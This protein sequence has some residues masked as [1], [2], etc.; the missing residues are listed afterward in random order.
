MDAAGVVTTPFTHHRRLSLRKG[1]DSMTTRT[2]NRLARLLHTA[3][4][5]TTRAL[6]LAVPC[7]LW[8]CSATTACHAEWR[9]GID[10]HP[11]KVGRNAYRF[12][13]KLGVVPQGDLQFVGS[14]YDFASMTRGV[15]VAYDFS[16]RRSGCSD[17]RPFL[18]VAPT[19]FNEEEGFMNG[20]DVT[21]LQDGK[22]SGVVHATAPLTAVHFLVAADGFAPVRRG[23]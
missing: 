7:G 13:I 22:F 3:R 2:L 9:Y 19:L 1:E 18:A 4:T 15:A 17:P 12:K 11:R 14:E 10:L 5:L 16:H 6:I 20:W 8:L 23:R 21:D